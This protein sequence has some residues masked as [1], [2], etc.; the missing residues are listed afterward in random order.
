M[1]TKDFLNHIDQLAIEH[2][3]TR[4]QI[5]EAFEKSLISGCKKNYQIKSCQ[6]IFN[7]NYEELSLYKEYLV[8]GPDSVANEENI[9]ENINIKKMTCVNLEEAQKLKNNPQIG[10]I[11]KIKVD[12]KEFNFYASKDF[13]NK[14]NEEIIRHKKE[15]IYNIFKKYEKKLIVAKVVSIKKN[16]YVLELEKEVQ[17]VLLN[18]DKLDNDDFVAGERIQ[19]YVVEVKQTT[20]MPKILVSRTCVEF[21]LEIFKEFIPEVQ[22][23]IIEIMGISRI[24][25]T[26]VKVGLFSHNS[27][28]DA[29]GSCI[30]SK[31]SRIKNIINVLKG[32]KIDLFLWSDEPKE[33]IANALQ[34]AK[35]SQVDILDLENKNASVLVNED[36]ISL[37][38][39]KSGN[40]VRLAAQV[41]KWNISIKTT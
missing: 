29:I 32:E 41:I 3:L 39:G 2:E 38:I 14:F 8:V 40:N 37:A 30:G 34:P 24:P 6:L 7:K 36:Q 35:I 17:T 33:L 11:I 18:K 9:D 26:R 12:P 10:E 31:S 20:K 13:K 15:N 1:K 22:E 19:V 27:N 23:G 21:V 5:L 28:I 4:E 16:L 25:S